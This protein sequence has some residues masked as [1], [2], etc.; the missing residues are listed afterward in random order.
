MEIM[1]VVAVGSLL[2]STSVALIQVRKAFVERRQEREERARRERE[3]SQ[4]QVKAHAERDAIITTSAQTAV[5]VL[6][7]TLHEVNEENARLRTRVTSLEHRE[8][9]HTEVLR[10]KNREINDLAEK[11]DRLGDQ[12]ERARAE[13]AQLRVTVTGD[14]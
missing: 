4:D 2:V 14:A 7:R 9:Q 12:L 3:R 6:E 1:Q 5:V 10:T 13:I 11:V 8:A